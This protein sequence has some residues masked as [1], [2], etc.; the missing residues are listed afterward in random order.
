MY[1]EGAEEEKRKNN[2][3]IDYQINNSKKIKFYRDKAY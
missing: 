1:P 3:Y 2:I